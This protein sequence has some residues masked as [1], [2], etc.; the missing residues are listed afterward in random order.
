VD[1]QHELLEIA[2]TLHPFGGLTNPTDCREEKGE[3]DTNDG[4]DD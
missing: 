2:P 4:D 3:Q 1:G